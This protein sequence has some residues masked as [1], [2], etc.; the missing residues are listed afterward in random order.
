MEHDTKKSI[1]TH[2]KWSMI[3]KMSILTVTGDKC[4]Q[5]SNSGS[6]PIE[7]THAA[8]M[9][10]RNSASVDAFVNRFPS[11]EYIVNKIRNGPLNMNSVNEKYKDTNLF[12]RKSKEDI[13]NARTA[14]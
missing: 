8:V 2:V 5:Y 1:L 3:Q 10:S 11:Q 4:N 9:K 13:V 14:I 6:I 12:I 7:L